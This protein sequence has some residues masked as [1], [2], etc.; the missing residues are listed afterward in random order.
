[1]HFI[2]IGEIGGLIYFPAL[3][4]P[5]STWAEVQSVRS[6][7]NTCVGMQGH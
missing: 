6:T 2:D 4:C 5:M 1:M 7:E 3:L